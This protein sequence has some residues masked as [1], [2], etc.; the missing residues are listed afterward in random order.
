MLTR[1]MLRP[2]RADVQ[3][4]LPHQR[5][6]TDLLYEL[7][8]FGASEDHVYEWLHD[9]AHG[10]SRVLL[11]SHCTSRAMRAI[12]E[13]AK[14][15][16]MRFIEEVHTAVADAPVPPDRNDARDMDADAISFFEHTRMWV[17]R[18]DVRR[19]VRALRVLRVVCAAIVL[20]AMVRRWRH[21][22]AQRLYAPGGAGY[23]IARVSFAT[24]AR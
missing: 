23:E 15:D 12:A 2:L 6:F 24:L 7:I 14:G 17:E 20:K 10:G 19:R 4:R 11:F 22:V 16:I 21:D 3:L 8:R 9:R 5:S 1:R 18:A 13:E